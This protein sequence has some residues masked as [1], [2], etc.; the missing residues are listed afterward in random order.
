M[1]RVES[2]SPPSVVTSHDQAALPF[3]YFFSLN[4]GFFVVRFLIFF[5]CNCYKL[6]AS[7][8]GPYGLLVVS[9]IIEMYCDVDYWANKMLA[10][11]VIHHVGV[12]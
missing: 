3:F 12:C 8:D 10:C 1:D 7:I 5:S 11:D 6:P 2:S 9:P 4:F